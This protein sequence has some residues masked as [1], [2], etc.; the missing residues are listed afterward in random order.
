MIL[1]VRYIRH[2]QRFIK[3]TVVVSLVVSIVI[4][5]RP[6]LHA[7]AQKESSKPGS[8]S[9]GTEASYLVDS[10]TGLSPLSDE[11]DL[12]GEMTL[13]PGARR[14]QDEMD[15]LYKDIFIKVSELSPEVKIAE[16]TLQQKY[17]ERYTAKA[18]R[19]APDIAFLLSQKHRFNYDRELG[20]LNDET[21][22]R[23]FT[24]DADFTDWEFD[25][26]LPIIRR[27]AVVKLDIAG[28]DY[29]L[30]ENEYNIKIHQLDSQLRELLGN[31]MVSVYRL[32]N[33]KNSVS[34]SEDH[35]SKIRRGYELRDQTRLALLR[36]QANLKGLE[37]RVD[38]ETQRRDTALRELLDFTGLEQQDPVLMQLDQLLVEE[39]QTAEVI[40]SFARV[41]E[42]LIAVEQYLDQMEDNQ[43]YR[44]Y[45]D[46]SELFRQ[47]ELQRDLSDARA[48]RFT[49]Q[50][51][52]DLAVRGD[53][54]RKED[55]YFTD[56]VSDGSIGLYLK[57]PIFSG[58]TLRSNLKAKSEA[59]QVALEQLRN[60]DRKIF[61]RIANRRKSILSLRDVYE[62]QKIN[63]L[64]QEEIVRLSIK[65]YTI[66][67]TSMQDLLTSKNRLI[68]AKNQLIRTT[69][70]IS[71]QAR[72]LAWELG[73]PLEP[74][75]SI[76]PEEKM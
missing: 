31:Y 68:E 42:S 45:Q 15:N 28:K 19:Y 74:P 6:Q 24:D 61:N 5:S 44:F 20:A 69:M 60:D 51:W 3:L 58:G 76:E 4:L 62:K 38:L 1:H 64:Q 56:F 63:L 35:V 53:Y 16:R 73:R 43:L 12:E 9:Y 22:E 48:D 27:S 46:N 72:L 40:S 49:Q 37:A 25:L 54:G 52:P 41:E 11:G 59:Q 10:A 70:D 7:Q 21:G 65:S 39:K 55:T 8:I 29:D 17:H 13:L 47:L 18:E 36:A 66:K 23:E 30:A 67:Q 71:S 50:E 34:L 57:V 2:L 32:L 33:L 75:Q 26:D 14:F